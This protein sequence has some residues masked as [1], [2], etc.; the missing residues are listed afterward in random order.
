MP[1]LTICIEHDVDMP[2]LLRGIA[3]IWEWQLDVKGSAIHLGSCH[4]SRQDDFFRAAQR[5]RQL[6]IVLRRRRLDEQDVVT[7]LG[8]IAFG[9][10]IDQ[11]C[12]HRSR[13]RPAPKFGQTGLIDLNKQD[14][15]IGLRREP[16][17]RA[18]EQPGTYFLARARLCCEHSGSQAQQQHGDP[19]EDQPM[20]PWHLFTCRR[21]AAQT[22]SRLQ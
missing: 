12:M 2:R 9:Q 17:R 13:P 7:D 4:I 6:R 3:Q 15:S 8:D 1:D 16:D 22:V 21:R 11:A 14:S 5:I 19:F 10:P 20:T 18:V